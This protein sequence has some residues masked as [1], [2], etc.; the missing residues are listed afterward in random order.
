ML[1]KD[2]QLPAEDIA[3]WIKNCDD[4]LENEFLADDEIITLATQEERYENEVED[5]DDA[6]GEKK[7]SHTEARPV[8]EVTLKYIEHK[9]GPSSIDTLVIKKMERCSI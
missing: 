6:E 8:K 4:E 1:S 2:V 5:A 3:E 9:P 7:V